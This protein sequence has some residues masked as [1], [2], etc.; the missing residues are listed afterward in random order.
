MTPEQRKAH[1]AQRKPTPKETKLNPSQE[2][3]RRLLNAQE[4][5]LQARLCL[6]EA[7]L[8]DNLVSEA[9]RLVGEA[10]Y[11]LHPRNAER[12]DKSDQKWV[13]NVGLTSVNEIPS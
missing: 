4:E 12:K 6:W 10:A 2:A 9:L 1:E 13:E 3:I 7:S 5:I 8:E 11:R